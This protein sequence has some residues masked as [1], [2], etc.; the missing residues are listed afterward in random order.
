[1]YGD[2]VFR[3]RD[4]ICVAQIITF[5]VSLLLA[6]SF[7]CTGRIGWFCVGSF[8]V[9]R[10]VGASCY[11]AIINND[12]ET[13]WATVFVCESL[14]IMLI[15]FLFLELLYR[16]YIPPPPIDRVNYADGNKQEQSIHKRYFFIPQLLTWI[17][18]VISVIGYI[19]IKNKNHNQL[20]PTSYDQASRAILCVIYI[21]TL[22]LLS[23][24]WRFQKISVYALPE[25]RATYAVVYAIPLMV[26]RLV[27]SIVFEATGDRRFNAS[28]GDP[29]VYL[30]MT[31][32]PELGIIAIC[33]ATISGIPPIE[34]K[35][36]EGGEGE[37][38]GE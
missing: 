9:I 31:Y 35:E 24:F 30:A 23:V 36:R 17:D 26:V 33:A 5:P 37:G 2:G 3:Y 32:L 12:S 8:S 1:M 14:G 28:K 10:L 20:D 27:Y 7:Y 6:T 25:R 13:L 4:G 16:V 29:T 21:Y 11:L 19:V 18:I 34:R 22:W 15:I 38:E